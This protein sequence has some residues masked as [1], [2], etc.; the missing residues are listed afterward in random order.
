MLLILLVMSLE[1]LDIVAG[2]P[3]P[4]PVIYPYPYPYIYPYPYPYRR[5]PRPQRRN[6]P[7]IIVE[8]NKVNKMSILMRFLT[9]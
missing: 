9:N 1:C 2:I 6:S 7:S 3:P 5:P 4:V 8:G